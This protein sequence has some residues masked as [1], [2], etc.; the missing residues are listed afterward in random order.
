MII[1]L[2]LLSSLFLSLCSAEHLSPRDGA[3]TLYSLP[4]NDHNTQL[5]AQQITTKRN[6]FLYGSSA[7]VGGGP[8]YPTGRLG[9]QTTLLDDE[10]LGIV[11]VKNQAEEESDL[12]NATTNASL[13]QVSLFPGTF[14]IA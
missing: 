7:T 5:R 12:A 9:N 13:K 6:K 2:F 11:V 3:S 1:R 8:F 4:M 10:S 14:A